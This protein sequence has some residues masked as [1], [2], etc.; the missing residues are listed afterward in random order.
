MTK[1]NDLDLYKNKY[2]IETL[3]ENIN[4]LYIKSIVNTQILTAKFCVKYILDECYMTCIEDTYLIDFNYVLQKQPHI[5]EAELRE[6]YDN[7]Y[8]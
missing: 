6:E 1:I 2:D 8:E 7:Y 4:H 5:T 3:T